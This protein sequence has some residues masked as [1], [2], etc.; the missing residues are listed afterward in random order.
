MK[1]LPHHSTLRPGQNPT[2]HI[3]HLYETGRVH[4][5]GKSPIDLYGRSHADAKLPKY[6][7]G[8][9][10]ELDLSGK[11][12]VQ[13]PQDPQDQRGPQY[14]NEPSIRSW[15]R[16]G[17]LRPSFDHGPSGKRYDK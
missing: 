14:H 12:N 15:V 7:G 9:G 8:D 13:A 6:G 3:A 16:G 10:L 2:L 1:K 4:P 11:V 5:H 17:T